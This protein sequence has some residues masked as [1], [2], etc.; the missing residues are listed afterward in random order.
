MTRFNSNY[1]NEG[2]EIYDDLLFFISFRTLANYFR[3]T[4]T[5]EE[6]IRAIRFNSCFI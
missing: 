6:R 2:T 3:T 1:A 5:V 4:S